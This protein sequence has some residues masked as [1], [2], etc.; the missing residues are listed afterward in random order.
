M[1]GYV[2]PS[3]PG[4][5]PGPSVPMVPMHVP[6]PPGQNV[7]FK[8]IYVNPSIIDPAVSPNVPVVGIVPVPGTVGVFSRVVNVIPAG[9]APQ[10]W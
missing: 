1:N 9:G 8:V 10:R 3:Y 4:Y 5:V 6:D 7:T 2:N